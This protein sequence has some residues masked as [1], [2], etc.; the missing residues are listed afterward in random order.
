MKCKLLLQ[1]RL[2]VWIEIN[3]NPQLMDEN[4]NFIKIFILGIVVCVLK[5]GIS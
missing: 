5:G 1:V 3:F 4:I 2:R